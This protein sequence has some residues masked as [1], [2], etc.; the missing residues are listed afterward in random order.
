MSAPD[1]WKTKDGEEIQV[2]DLR[3]GHLLNILAMVRRKLPATRLDEIR[4]LSSLQ[5]DIAAS[6]MSGEMAIDSLEGE[7]RR[8]M[9]W[10][11]DEAIAAVCPQWVALLEEQ[12]KRELWEKS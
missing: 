1:V 9:D 12:N 10:D 4:L 5:C 11:D 7:A 6:T 2:S 3:D 8:C